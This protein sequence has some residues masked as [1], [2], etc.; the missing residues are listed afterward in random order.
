MDRR[1]LATIL[2]LGVCKS[3]AFFAPVA[4]GRLLRWSTSGSLHRDPESKLNPA[5]GVDSVDEDEGQSRRDF[6]GKGL[7][8]ASMLGL[9]TAEPNNQA[10]AADFGGL[11]ITGVEVKELLH[12]GAGESSGNAKKPLLD[13]LINIERVSESTKQVRNEREFAQFF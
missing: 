11:E 1:I 5:T 4:V 12:P 8:G 6:L 2:A 9:L 3:R 13:C 10:L 7:A